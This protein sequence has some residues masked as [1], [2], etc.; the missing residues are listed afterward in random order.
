MYQTINITLTV[1]NKTHDKI[2]GLTQCEEQS[3]D[4]SPTMY[5]QYLIIKL[6]LNFQ[7]LINTFIQ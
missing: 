4:N 1:K 5:N 7:I 6:Y 3:M 2:Y